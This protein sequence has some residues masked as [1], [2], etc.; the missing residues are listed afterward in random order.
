M[1]LFKLLINKTTIMKSVLLN[2][3]TVTIA[4]LV[5]VF[6]INGQITF[7]YTGLSQT[8]TVPAGVTSISITAAGAQGG[9]EGAG[10]G[11][12][13]IMSAEYSVTPGEVLTL[14]V[15]QQGQLQIG[16]NYQNSSGGGGGTFVYN[17]S[18][19][20][21]V[22]AGGGGGKCNF[23]GSP[24]LH[25]DAHGK[26]TQ[27]GGF[28]SS[29][30]YAGGTG[31]A[32]GNAGLWSGTPC[33]GGGTGWLS[34]GGSIHGGQGLAGSWAGGSPFCGGG[35]GG[36]GGFGG[37]G[38]GGGGGNHY[39]GGGGGGGYSG[40]GGGTDPT[41]GGGGGS[42]STG[43]NPSNTAGAQ[44]GNGLVTITA[45]CSS[46]T[47]TPNVSNLSDVNAE[48]SISP[49]APTAT[50]DCGQQVNGTS[51]VSFPITALGTTVVTWTYNDG[52]SQVTQT[53]NIIISDLTAPVPDA[54]SLPDLV[55]QC[56]NIPTPPTATDDCSGTI[57]ATAN[58]IFPITTPGN[59][60]ITWTFDDGNGNVSTQTQNVTNDPIDISVSVNGSQLEANQ[61]VASY[62]WLD[63]GDNFSV[64]S[65]AVNQMFTPANTGN[66]AVEITNTDGC[67]DTSACQLIDFTGIDVLLMNGTKKVVGIVDLLGRKTQFVPN[68]PLI[69]IY[70]DGTHERV[71][72]L[73]E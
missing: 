13:A 21:L 30:A 25:A 52:V 49:V 70:N 11:Y 3:L 71:L 58:M 63:C 19:E 62:Q 5:M 2:C 1:P 56:G 23:T 20:L 67:A 60:V 57:T 65:G 50:N 33:A 31:G 24:A 73:E 38:G 53:Q 4:L 18:N 14:I 35:G 45:L 27:N 22:A 36:C 32:G 46:T 42:Y 7:N 64:I 55:D 69:Y 29:G 15:G 51:N 44:T 68:T 8:Y 54:L 61:L 37:F 34:P 10:G 72:K 17:S 16:G 39:G 26:I 41:H 40:G 6:G 47:L 59:S 48:C 66:Y 12:G 9:G 28:D 43:T